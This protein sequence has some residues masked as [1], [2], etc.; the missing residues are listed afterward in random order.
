MFIKINLFHIWGVIAIPKSEQH[1][2]RYW[3]ESGIHGDDRLKFIYENKTY[4]NLHYILL[5][6][7]CSVVDSLAL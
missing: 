1:L 7:D 6:Y 3:E 2:C 4:G 5:K